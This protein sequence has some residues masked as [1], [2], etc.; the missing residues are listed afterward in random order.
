MTGTRDFRTGVLHL[1]KA[2]GYEIVEMDPDSIAP[3][4]WKIRADKGDEKDTKIAIMMWEGD[5]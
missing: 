1:L 2:A 5:V 3:F 4:I